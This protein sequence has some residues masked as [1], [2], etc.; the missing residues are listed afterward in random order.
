MQVTYQ[1][2]CLDWSPAGFFL[3]VFDTSFFLSE[4]AD[5]EGGG[6]WQP[7][8]RKKDSPHINTLLLLQVRGEMRREM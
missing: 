2:T 3:S 1:S 5:P 4:T 8:T 6:F 7:S